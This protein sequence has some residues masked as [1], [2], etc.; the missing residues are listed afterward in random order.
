MDKRNVRAFESF[1]KNFAPQIYKFASE[2][3]CKVA[4][5]LYGHI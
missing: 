2:T 4:N 5:P 1:K 3:V